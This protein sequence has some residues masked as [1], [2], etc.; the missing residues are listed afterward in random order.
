MLR[1]GVVMEQGM[2]DD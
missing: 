1:H 2:N